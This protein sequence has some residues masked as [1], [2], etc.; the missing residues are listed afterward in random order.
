M[1]LLSALLFTY[2][3]SLAGT[4][5]QAVVRTLTFDDTSPFDYVLI[6]NGYGG[7]QWN[8]FFIQNG[9]NAP[10]FYRGAVSPPN[11]AFNGLGNQASISSST[12]FTLIS[13]YLTAVYV[14]AQQIRV[15][16]FTGGARVYNNVY[17]VNGNAPTLVNFN[18][19]GVDQVTFAIITSPSGIF[20]M[21]NLV[22]SLRVVDSDGDGVPDDEDQCSDTPPGAFVD[23]HGCSIDQLVPCEGPRP[24]VSWKSHG[25]YVAAIVRLVNR[26]KQE[27]LI[28]RSKA[29]QII[30]TAAQSDCGKKR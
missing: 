16:G 4:H 13:A 18:Y 29:S 28:T 17:D 30:I 23:S 15:Q 19:V 20:A 7:L 3:M 22:I 6:E 12:A 5:A 2:L 26:L 24:G 14:D 10:G 1:K 8:N 21:D 27:G 9:L 11:V 25:Q